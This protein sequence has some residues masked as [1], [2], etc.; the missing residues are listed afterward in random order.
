MPQR[1]RRTYI[2]AYKK[3]SLIARSIK[4]P[5]DWLEH[6]GVFASAFPA[7][8]ESGGNEL[9]SVIPFKLKAPEENLADITE[10]FNK[11]N[12]LRPFSNA[13]FM[14]DGQVW[15]EKLIPAYTGPCS[16]LGDILAT[17]KE[18]ELI[19]ED[20]YISQEDL[21]QWQYLKGAKHELRR[22]KEGFEFTYNEGGMAFPDPLDK[23]S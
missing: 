20:F 10:H 3:D 8:S 19:T 9:F 2:L 12:K 17:G 16:T 15:T 6:D 21:P 22:T 14:Y 23:P 18:R 4:N 13:G 11:S 1:R 7:V 5:V